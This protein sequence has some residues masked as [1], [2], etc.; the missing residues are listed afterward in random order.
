MGSRDCVF[1]AISGFWFSIPG[2]TTCDGFTQ[3]TEGATPRQPKATPWVWESKKDIRPVRA[4]RN[5]LRQRILQGD[6]TLY[7]HA[8]S[9]LIF[10]PAP[11]LPRALPWVDESTRF[12]REL[13]PLVLVARPGFQGL[14][15]FFH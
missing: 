3:R 10:L 14:R 2:E 15:P 6:W 4:K 1:M 7:G 12:Q 9:G 11:S 13:L 5:P 8:L